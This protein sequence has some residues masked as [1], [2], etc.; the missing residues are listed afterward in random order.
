MSNS[1]RPDGKEPDIA[2]ELRKVAAHEYADARRERHSGCAEVA[3]RSEYLGDRMKGLA[4]ALSS[5]ERVVQGC[6]KKIDC[7]K[8]YCRTIT[9]LCPGCRQARDTAIQALLGRTE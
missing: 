6:G 7:T 9:S 3:A 5:L 2:W 8:R 1:P 4:D